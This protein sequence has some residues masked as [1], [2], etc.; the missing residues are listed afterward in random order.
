MAAAHHRTGS[1]R[2][3]TLGFA[4]LAVVLVSGL[5]LGIFGGGFYAQARGQAS[6]PASS[7][8][9]EASSKNAMV[10]VELFTSEGCSSCPPAD[11]LLSSLV[12]K[13]PV[14]GVTIIGMSE[15]VEYW[16]D[17]GWVDPFSSSTYGRRQNDYRVNAF[18][19]GG[20]Y[21]P[22]MI[23]D[24]HL[25]R[26][27]NDVTG[28]YRAVLQAA[29]APKAAVN[30]AAEPQ[31]GEGGL[32]IRISLNIP[33]EVVVDEGADVVV[34]LTEDNLESDVSRGEN[35]GQHLKH[36]AVVRVLQTAGTLT[37]QDAAQARAWSGSATIPVMPQWKPNDLRV[38][39]FLQEQ[40]SRRILGA[41]W[42]KVT[43]DAPAVNQTSVAN[44]I[45]VAN[46]AFPTARAS[47]ANQTVAP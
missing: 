9:A 22:Q 6:Q 1:Q 15:H 36:T 38:V 28:V 37:F 41:G 24:G 32:K 42:T 44:Q 30:V 35:H 21:T 45:P 20:L 18:S 4:P 29:S 47:G 27:G 12:R 16:N 43:G 26:V 14:P 34:A 39:A 17:D 46:R 25:A 40:M 3:W 7:V 31:P 11:D 23:L 10:V 13:Q 8:G 5:A 33:R 19:G 2:G